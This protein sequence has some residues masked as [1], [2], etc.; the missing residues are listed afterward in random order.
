MPVQN[1]ALLNLRAIARAL[2]ASLPELLAADPE[3]QETDN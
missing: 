2:R 3:G 1:V